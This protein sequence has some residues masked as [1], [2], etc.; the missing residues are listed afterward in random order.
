[1]GSVEI[2]G[3]DTPLVGAISTSEATLTNRTVSN[4]GASACLSADQSISSASVTHV[5]LDATGFDDE[6]EFDTTNN[7]FTAADA[8][9]YY[10]TAAALWDSPGSNTEIRSLIQVSG[11]ETAVERVVTGNN[12]NQSCSI[13][14]V[15]ELSAGDTVSW[16][17][18]QDSGGSVDIFGNAQST[19]MQIIHLG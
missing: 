13:T 3:S 19:Y 12:G 16:N 10:V 6:S 4:L 5:A 11:V 15:E 9:I 7:E 18:R 1:M 14:T 17:V 2:L 8:G